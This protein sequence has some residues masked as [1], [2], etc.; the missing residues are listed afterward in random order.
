MRD[1]TPN[2]FVSLGWIIDGIIMNLFLDRINQESA[3]Y[4]N[5]MSTK[6][7]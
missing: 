1:Y 2:L 6:I 4:S 5:N 7:E 3:K